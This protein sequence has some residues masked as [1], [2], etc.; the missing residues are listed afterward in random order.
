MSK[1][2]WSSQFCYEKII[3]TVILIMQRVYIPDLEHRLYI[4]L[5]TNKTW[6]YEQDKHRLLERLLENRSL[7]ITQ[8]NW[9]WYHLLLYYHKNLFFSLYFKQMQINCCRNITFDNRTNWSSRV[10]SI[11]IFKIAL[12]TYK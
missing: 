12:I 2:H 9:N 8:F 10:G 5:G 11:L 1:D 4:K 6:R 7:F 3:I